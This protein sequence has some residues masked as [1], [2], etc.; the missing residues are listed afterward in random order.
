MDVLKKV[1][2]TVRGY[3][4]EG[5]LQAFYGAI[6]SRDPHGAPQYRE[7]KRDFEAVRHNNERFMIF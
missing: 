4:T 2:R 5:S 3:N 1:A 7:T 6:A